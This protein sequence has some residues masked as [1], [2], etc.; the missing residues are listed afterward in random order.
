MPTNN[1]IAQAPKPS[2][3]DQY[4]STLGT[5]CKY[6]KDYGG[7]PSFLFSPYS[8]IALL[9]TIVCKNYAHSIRWVDLPKGV[10]PSII[11]FSIA[12][13][14]LWI[15]MLSG[16][17]KDIFTKNAKAIAI[18]SNINTTFFHFIFIQIVAFMYAIIAESKPAAFIYK[19]IVTQPYF[20]TLQ[21]TQGA[22]DTFVFWM[23]AIGLYLFIYAVTLCLAS[24]IALFQ[25]GGVWRKAAEKEL[26][27]KTNPGPPPTA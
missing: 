19:N 17:L 25:I 5:L 4:K 14:S 22:W 20:T 8:L 26:A 1:Q 15:S 24:M 27:S 2:R 13:F 23:Y 6:A 3:L 18:A 16:G 11:G 10:L 7:I 12:A 21:I 9:I